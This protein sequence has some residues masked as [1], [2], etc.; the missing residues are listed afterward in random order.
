MKVNE[1]S[2]TVLAMQARA[3]VCNAVMGGTAAMREA[4]RT[5]LPQEPREDDLSWQ[6]RLGRTVLFPAFRRAVQTM[7]GKPLGSPI[8][9]DELDPALESAAENIDMSGRDL[10]TFA[11]QVLEQTL[12]DGIGWVLVDHTPVPTGATLAT[13]REMKAGP[14]FVHV[15]LSRVLGWKVEVAHGVPKVVQ[16]RFAECAEVPD[17]EFGTK[18]EQRVRVWEPGLVRVFRKVQTTNG[19]EWIEAPELGGPV[20]L[21]DE[22]PV[23]PIYTGRTGFWEAVPPLEDMAWL[24]VQ[25][26]QSS[27]DQRH[28]LHVARV[29]LLGADE[30]TRANPAAPVTIGPDRLIVGLKGLR[31]IEHSGGAIG[32][33]RQDLLDLEDMMR[34]VAGEL[35]A[36]VAGDKSATEA[37][38]EGREGAS[39]LRAWVWS[40]QDALEECFRLAAKWIGKPDGGSVEISTD[41]DDEELGFQMIQQ[42]TAARTAGL[43]S[44]DTYLWNLKRAELLPPDTELEDEKAALEAEGPV[45]LGPAD[46]LAPP[47][48]KVKKVTVT[49]NPDGSHTGT[50]EE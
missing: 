36:R 34:R 14:F 18:E 8:V 37:G 48:K 46:P 28:V 43:I 50:V 30:D 47:P 20:T 19:E 15:P 38:M 22:I 5:Y 31:Y 9:L 6:S 24:N 21:K 44:S 39:Q 3:A 33:G 45:G 23:V 41:W 12:T 32:A 1:P 25:H 35:L 17:G 27:S 16:F 11:R 40:F 2:S 10:D 29:P 42:L 7:V 49:K 26:W 13:E 4:G